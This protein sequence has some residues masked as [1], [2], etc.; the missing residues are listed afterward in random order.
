MTNLPH[1]A[2]YYISYKVLKKLIK[3]TEE[4]VES[5]CE[6]SEESITGERAHFC[7]RVPMS[8]SLGNTNNDFPETLVFFTVLHR[9][10]E[11]VN[12]FYVYKRAELERRMRILGDKA[13]AGSSLADAT[14]P[15]EDEEE[16]GSALLEALLQV[17]SQAE[18]LLYYAEMCRK[19]FDKI[20]KK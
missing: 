16:K 10:L 3:S 15:E 20:L 1:P 7:Q 13:N 8:L 14:E 6:P 17:K 9:E 11:K 2:R 5:G 19:G 12:G 18:D 4:C